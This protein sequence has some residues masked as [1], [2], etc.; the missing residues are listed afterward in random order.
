M[1]ISPR[2]PLLLLLCSVLWVSA[3]CASAKDKPAPPAITPKPYGDNSGAYQA[4]AYQQQAAANAPYAGQRGTSNNASG[5][6]GS[7]AYEAVTPSARPDGSAPASGYG[8]TTSSAYPTGSTYGT[9]NAGQQYAQGVYTPPAGTSQY[10]G[11]AGGGVAGSNLAVSALGQ[12]PGYTSAT[13]G[14]TTSFN[15][16]EWSAQESQ[17]ALALQAGNI[18]FYYDNAV[19]TADAKAVLKQKA[20]LLTQFPA[21]RM[22]ISGHCDSRGSEAYNTGLGERRAKAAYAYLMELGVRSAQLDY[23]SY[24]SQF[25]VAAGKGES[26]WSQNRRCEFAVIKSMR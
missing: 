19:L 24:G 6:S 20:S 14:K 21:L 17:T 13:P 9:G 12:T 10:V 8:Q 5:S 23:V 22:T 4:N 25:P 18:Y 3:G 1:F 15:N 7:G 26:N 11:Q 2:L 16:G